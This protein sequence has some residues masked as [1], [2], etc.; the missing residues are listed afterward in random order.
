MAVINMRF[1]VAAVSDPERGANPNQWDFWGRAPLYAGRRPQHASRTAAG[2]I[3]PSLD[4]TTSLQVIELLLEAGANPNPQLK[5]PPPFR[6]VGT[7]RGL[8]G[9]L[10][11]G[12]TPLLRAAKALDAPAIRCC[13]RKAPTCRSPN[14]R[15]ITP[16]MAAAGLGSVD[17][18]TRGFYLTED[19]QQRSIESLKLLLSGRRRDQRERL[20]AARR[21]CTGRVLGLERRRPVPRRHGADLNAKDNRGN[22]A[23]RLG[24]WQSGRQQPRRPAHRRP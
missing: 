7:D 16:V 3:V 23:G 4:K 14:S 9:M 24:A 11:I 18:D 6:N 19:T 12:T 15:G 1:D 13:S 17:A 10:T 20:T 22:D 21:R 8:D 2:P 5:L